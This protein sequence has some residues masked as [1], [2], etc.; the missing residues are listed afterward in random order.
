MEWLCNVD[1]AISSS[2]NLSGLG[3][4][5]RDSSNK[6]VSTIT[7]HWQGCM[8][9]QVVEALPLWQALECWCQHINRSWVV[10]IDSQKVLHVLWSTSKNRSYFECILASEMIFISFGFEG[11]QI[12]L[13]TTWLGHRH[14][15]LAFKFGILFLLVF[16]FW[17]LLNKD[18]T[19]KRKK[20]V[21]FF[22]MNVLLS[23]FISW[24]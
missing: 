12:W 14:L 9:P 10:E 18:F 5:T 19:S 24:L 2:L 23:I 8:E 20:K 6:F 22:N 17:Y 11:K 16:H 1:E 13:L 3:A 4:Y 21:H 15:M 7:R